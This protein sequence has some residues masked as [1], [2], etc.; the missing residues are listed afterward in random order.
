MLLLSR[1]QGFLTT[2][3][4]ISNISVAT[5]LSK[6]SSQKTNSLKKHT[7]INEKHQ[8]VEMQNANGLTQMQAEGTCPAKI[9]FKILEGTQAAL[10]A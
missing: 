4:Y 2:T 7:H 5:V 1:D 3:F 6:R 8:V 10:S 9:C